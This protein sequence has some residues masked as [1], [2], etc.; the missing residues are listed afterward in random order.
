MKMKWNCK[1][2]QSKSN[3]ML[4]LNIEETC[5]RHVNGFFFVELTTNYYI[6]L[7]KYNMRSR[8]EN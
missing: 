6:E 4:Q 2:D 8:G 7:H 5:L 3:T 1:N